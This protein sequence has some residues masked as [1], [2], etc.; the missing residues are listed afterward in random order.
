MKKIS[1]FLPFFTLLV[2]CNP[3]PTPDEATEEVEFSEAVEVE[4][5]YYDGM[6]DSLHTFSKTEWFESQFEK[7][8]LD[9]NSNFYYV[10]K[11]LLIYGNENGTEKIGRLALGEKVEITRFINGTYEPY[12]FDGNFVEI[13]RESGEVGFVYDGYLLPLPYPNKEDYGFEEY[14]KNHL[15]IIDSVKST[16]S[17]YGNEEEIYEQDEGETT[18]PYEN[19]I[20]ISTS[21]YYEGDSNMIELNIL[22]VKEGLIFMDALYEYTDLIDKLDGSLEPGEY[23]FESEY[24]YDY[25]SAM[26]KADK[27]GEV[28]NISFEVGDGCSEWFEVRKTE[29]GI[30]MS[31]GGGC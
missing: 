25:S 5:D 14:G 27:N 21:Y 6:Y 26:I 1:L 2:N 3:S 9:P 8:Q 10:Y 19:N 13:R 15:R 17:Y 18:Y 22:S 12:T 31:A 4:E 24:E 20:T 28:T 23:E 16:G 11:E 29:T 30:Y 7:D